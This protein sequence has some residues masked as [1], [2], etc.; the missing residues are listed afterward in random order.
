MRVRTLFLTMLF[1]V[2]LVVPVAA[3]QI[4]IPRYTVIP[5][6]LDNS[7]SSTTAQVG[8]TFSSHCASSNCGG[9]PANTT[10]IGR[11]TSV[12][13]ASGRNP[14]QIGVTFTSAVLPD[15]TRVPIIGSLSS[16]NPNA[17]TNESGRFVARSERRGT[18]NRFIGYGAGLGAVIGAVAGNTLTGALIGA[19]AGWLTG[20]TVGRERQGYDVNIPAGSEVGVM[21]NQDVVLPVS[22]YP[23]DTSPGGAGPGYPRPGSYCPPP[24]TELV[25]SQSKPFVNA[26]GTYMVSLR[27]VMNA[28]DQRFTTNREDRTITF[29]SDRGRIEYPLGTDVVYV[30]GNARNLSAPS[31]RVNGVL[32][33]PADFI[34]IT[35]GRQVSFNSRTGGLTIQ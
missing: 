12:V 35:T 26:E 14:G 32:Y 27:D 30:N 15:G 13:R 33:V 3:Q 2:A 17:I 6:T 8:Q 34:S 20:A 31:T 4:V 25:Y 5:V 11:I 16:L 28:I 21:L 7:L 22:T 24:K 1:L 18:D 10:F 23:G 9:F 19:A 29:R